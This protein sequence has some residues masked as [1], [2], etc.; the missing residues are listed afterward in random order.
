MFVFNDHV[1]DWNFEK[2]FSIDRKADQS[3][4]LR[5]TGSLR[6]WSFS[7]EGAFGRGGTLS[8][9]VLG[10]D[11][12]SVKLLGRLLVDEFAEVLVTFKSILCGLCFS[13]M[14]AELVLVGLGGPSKL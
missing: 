14:K 10:V 13:L 5:L 4:S 2:S 7:A 6:L 3:S 12:L 1:L 9:D 8:V 11:L